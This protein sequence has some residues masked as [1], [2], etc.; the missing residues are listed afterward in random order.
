MAFP[1]STEKASRVGRHRGFFV[2]E[3]EFSHLHNDREIDIRVTRPEIKRY[4]Q[5]LLNAAGVTLRKS[6][7]DWLVIDISQ[8]SQKLTQEMLCVAYDHARK[9]AQTARRK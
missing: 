5:I 2:G 6:S 1:E 4:R 9:A 8:C 7:S 3:K